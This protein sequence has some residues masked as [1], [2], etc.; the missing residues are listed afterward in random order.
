MSTATLGP[1]AGGGDSQKPE[2]EG[3]QRQP[4]EAQSQTLQWVGGW[5]SEEHAETWKQG[6]G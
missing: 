5:E 1:R 4:R 2:S 6:P 3:V